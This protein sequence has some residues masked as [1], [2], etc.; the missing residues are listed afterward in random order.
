MERLINLRRRLLELD[1]SFEMREFHNPDA[2]MPG[3][4]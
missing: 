2:D 4:F 3:E 1:M